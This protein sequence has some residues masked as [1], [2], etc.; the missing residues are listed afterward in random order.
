MR[1]WQEKF[2]EKSQGF[3][4][5]R[6]G[7]GDDLY[8]VVRGYIRNDLDIAYYRVNNVIEHV[9]SQE[10]ME[11]QNAYW[12][13]EDAIDHWTEVANDP[14]KKVVAMANV[15]RLQKETITA[16]DTSREEL[17]TVLRYATDRGFNIVGPTS[18]FLK[19]LNY[20]NYLS[21]C[22]GMDIN[23]LY[24]D[25]HR[26]Y[27]KEE[28]E[29]RKKVNVPPPPGSMKPPGVDVSRQWDGNSGGKGRSL[30]SRLKKEREASKEPKIDM[31]K[32]YDPNGPK[33]LQNAV[34][35]LQMQ[36]KKKAQERLMINRTK[37]T[38][39]PVAGTNFEMD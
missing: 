30:A 18:F 9:V 23:S 11:I 24:P 8:S 34:A 39:R 2:R 26:Y 27:S 29:F 37:H 14:A 21:E 7:E 13:G 28:Y 5:L 6:P 17:A 32:P 12:D 16:Y 38:M 15:R 31:N 1:K 20:D 3:S 4:P 25:D 22:S 19:P 36:E 33:D 35:Y 10:A